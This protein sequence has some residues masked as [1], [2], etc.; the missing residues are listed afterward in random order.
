MRDDVESK[1]SHQEEFSSRARK[2]RWVCENEMSKEMWN[3]SHR[4]LSRFSKKLFLEQSRWFGWIGNKEIYHFSFCPTH[5][6]LYHHL[7]HHFCRH[8]LMVCLP[9]TCSDPK[10]ARPNSPQT[11]WLALSSTP[12]Q[13]HLS[14]ERYMMMKSSFIFVCFPS[15]S[16]R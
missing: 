12:I 9:L 2:D 14:G 3:V 8:S 16:P 11:L 6:E 4:K 15:V 1:L 10:I 13:Q 5:G 7:H